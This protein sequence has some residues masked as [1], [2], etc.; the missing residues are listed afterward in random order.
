MERCPYCGLNFDV[1]DSH[2][3]KCRI[4]EHY[5]IIKRGNEKCDHEIINIKV[6]SNIK[7]NEKLRLIATFRCIYCDLLINFD[8]FET[9]W[10][11]DIK[12]IK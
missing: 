5:T 11:P 6:D 10:L 12:R 2:L 7:S 1:I 4:K 8:T 9:V 3:N